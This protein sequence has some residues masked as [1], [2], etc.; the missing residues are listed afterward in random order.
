MCVACLYKTT[1]VDRYIDLSVNR[2]LNNKEPE[3]KFSV[4]NISMSVKLFFFF[5]MGIP[6]EVVNI[7]DFVGP[8]NLWFK[9]EQ[10]LSCS[11]KDFPNFP[12]PPSAEE[13]K[14]WRGQGGL[15]WTINSS[16]RHATYGDT[17]K[18]WKLLGIRNRVWT[19]RKNYSVA[20]ARA[21]VSR[22]W[23]QKRKIIS[24]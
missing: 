20:L 19:F 17:K 14:K 15:G 23:K 7:N 10:I 6:I 5:W 4:W 9:K 18:N 8:L 22:K 12:W 2:R 16:T 13:Q 3:W 1:S 11:W 24:K 21:L